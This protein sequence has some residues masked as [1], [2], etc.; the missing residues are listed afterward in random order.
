MNLNNF[1][2][3]I[4]EDIQN[5]KH[6]NFREFLEIISHFIEN[7]IDANSTLKNVANLEIDLITKTNYLIEFLKILL[8]SRLLSEELSGSYVKFNTYKFNKLKMSNLIND[9]NDF[10]NCFSNIV[11]LF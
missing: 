9:I 4:I 8:K 2:I 1:I 7:K 6:L 5:N 3:S 10:R 11:L